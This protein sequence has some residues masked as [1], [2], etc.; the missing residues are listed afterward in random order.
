MHSKR[1]QEKVK[2][3][4]NKIADAFSGT[5]QALWKDFNVFTPYYIPDSDVLDLGC[6]NG[7]LLYYLEK[8]GF[9][10]YL[11]V[12]QSEALLQLARSK[13]PDQPFYL[14]DMSE[15]SHLDQKF[16][17]IFVIA[18]FHHLPP[19]AQLKAL[20]EWKKL[21]KPGGMIFMSNW[22]LWQMRFWPL[23]VKH[24]FYPRFGFLGLLV[25]WHSQVKRYYYAFTKRRLKLLFLKAGFSILEH[26]YVRHG[27]VSS[28][29]R[30]QNILSILQ[31]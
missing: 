19:D 14:S 30:G 7:R 10:S 11:G 23:W 12:D 4:Y 8:Q 13:H 20:K 3:D 1:I 18:S 9:R 17:S 26:D 25:P 28:R 29:L 31:A 16:D 2:E 21:L 24:F 6:G 27:K 5:R 22:N 15:L